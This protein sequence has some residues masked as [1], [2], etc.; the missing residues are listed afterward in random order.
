MRL[1]VIAGVA[2]PGVLSASFAGA[3]MPGI[4]T[5]DFTVQ[6]AGHV[7]ARFVFA[8]AEPLDTV[9]LDRNHDGVVTPE[10]VADARA[11]L[12]AFILDGVDLSADGVQCQAEFGDA[13]LREIDGLVITTSYVCPDD[14]SKVEATLY[15]LNTLPPGHREIARIVAGDVTAEAVVTAENRAI[16]VTLPGSRRALGTG[17]NARRIWVAGALVA[18]VV[19]ALVRVAGRE[20]ATR[21]AKRERS[22]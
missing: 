22:A 16:E 9:L 2:V 10:E 7:Q 21:R 15:Y 18:V 3:H 8:T 19:A 11:D 1:S 17:H 6:S 12:E 20:R 4:S 14:A 13:V 5:A